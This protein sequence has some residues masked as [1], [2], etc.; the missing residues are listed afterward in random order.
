MDGRGSILLV[1]DE[2]TFRESTCRLL[3]REGFDCHYACDGD[4]A[5]RALQER[6][7]DVMVADI[8]MPNNPDLRVVRAARERDDQIAV[9]L[10]TGYPSTETAIRAIE[11]SVAAYVTKPLDF[12]V[13][14]GRINETIKCS[15]NQ[16][17]MAAIQGRLQTCLAEL[18]RMRSKAPRVAGHDESVSIGTVRTL[19]A[20]LSELL[21]LGTRSGMD[22]GSY[23]LC[24]LLDCAQRP[25]HRQA[26]VD[27][28]EVLKR[29]KDTF[30]SKALADLRT[31]LEGYL[32]HSQGLP[33]RH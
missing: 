23:N 21:Q 6:R 12:D 30:K 27:A 3:R 19:A 2:E 9:I 24:E 28:I 18:E 16:L 26:V 14:L 10:V 5:V 1:D 33:P 15:G 20:C 7:F 8:R 11:L 17:A 4:D 32:G 31:K 22:W 25:V 13:L 29:T